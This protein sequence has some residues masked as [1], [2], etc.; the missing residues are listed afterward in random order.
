M[1][2][3]LPFKL[4]KI[5]YRNDIRRR[6]RREFSFKLAKNIQEW[7]K[8]KNEEDEDEEEEYK[9]MWMSHK[10]VRPLGPTVDDRLR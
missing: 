4:A 5:T 8:K 10:Q 6:K 2:R 3:P 7:Y 1:R 9:W